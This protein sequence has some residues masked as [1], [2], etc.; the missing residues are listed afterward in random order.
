MPRHIKLILVLMLTLLAST[1][2]A[3]V[4]F[5]TILTEKMESPVLDLTADSDQDLVF[6]LTPNAV[7]FYSPGEKA[8][9]DR[10]PLSETF[11]RITVLDGDRLVLSTDDPSRM[12]IL[13]Y[14]R[15]YSIDTTGRAF[16]GPEDAKVTLVVFDDYQCPYC[17]RLE[18]FIEQVLTQFP[19]EGKYVIKQFPLSSHAFAHQAA[20]A[21]LA[22]GKQGK[23]WEFH[24]R[25]L[26][27]HD[28]VNEQKIVDIAGE[29]GLDMDQFNKDRQLESS[30]QRIREDIEN[31]KR[32]G[33]TGTPAAF[34]NGKRIRNRELGTLPQLI[35]RELD[36]Q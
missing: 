23:F 33:V 15:I 27:N 1:V 20:M 26:A 30:R 9:V 34:I 5:E 32:I 36:D 17:A 22:A 3:D 2:Q 7:L 28:Q 24:S 4:S 16:K 18:R 29:L 6:L 31:G 13:R 11:D 21:A 10:I 19:N 8:V 12:T 14:D 35:I 25:L